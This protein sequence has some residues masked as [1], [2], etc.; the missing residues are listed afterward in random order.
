MTRNVA[1]RQEGT[2]DTCIYARAVPAGRLVV[3]YL[4]DWW[5][6]RDQTNTSFVRLRRGA[7]VS[8]G[9]LLVPGKGA[10]VAEVSYDVG[11][12]WQPFS[13]GSLL[14]HYARTGGKE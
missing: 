4:D 9:V 5:I 6:A 3:G 1:R 14:D 12:T 2:F 13:L 10:R 8:H 7:V 11:E